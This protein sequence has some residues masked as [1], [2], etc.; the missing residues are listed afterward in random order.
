M[1]LRGRSV[2]GGR[3]IPRSTAGRIISRSEDDVFEQGTPLTTFAVDDIQR[4]Y[5][6]MKKPGVAF[7]MEPTRTGPA[8]VAIFDEPC[9]TFIQLV[10]A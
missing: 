7:S 5:E 10:Q 2:S 6:R 9:G 8:T 4:E 3:G 1:S